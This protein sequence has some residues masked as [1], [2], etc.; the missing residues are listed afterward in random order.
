MA[1]DEAVNPGTF[2]TNLAK[3][4][5]ANGLPTLKYSLGQNT[6]RL[7]FNTI[8]G[9]GMQSGLLAQGGR[10]HYQSAIQILCNA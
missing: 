7:F 3:G 9:V 1:L 4:C 10:G 2:Q 5:E 6:A 8:C